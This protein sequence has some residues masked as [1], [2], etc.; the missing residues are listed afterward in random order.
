MGERIEIMG[1]REEGREGRW[2]R[3]RDGEREMEG[4]AGGWERQRKV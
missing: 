1:E 3:G 4:R 2:E